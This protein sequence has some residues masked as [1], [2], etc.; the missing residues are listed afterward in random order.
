LQ[1]ETLNET[2]VVGSEAMARNRR[3][4]LNSLWT[5]APAEEEKKELVLGNTFGERQYCKKSTIN[6]DGVSLLDA[7]LSV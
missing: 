1:P 3:R 4:G 7:V 6:I 2:K 5:L